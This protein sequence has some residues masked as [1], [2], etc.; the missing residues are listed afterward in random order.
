MNLKK[1]IYVSP[2]CFS[3]GLKQWTYEY[4]KDGQF[5]RTRPF[6]YHEGKD[7]IR[8]LDIDALLAD[9]KLRMLN[10]F[11]WRELRYT[12]LGGNHVTADGSSIT[13]NSRVQY[14]K[15]LKETQR[16]DYQTKTLHQLNSGEIVLQHIFEDEGRYLGFLK[17]IGTRGGVRTEHGYCVGFAD[18]EPYLTRRVGPLF[19]TTKEQLH[20]A[21]Q[22][23]KGL[24]NQKPLLSWERSSP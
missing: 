17:I 14:V 11:Q 16:T 24:L 5:F 10:Q 15:F 12:L 8:S 1:Y 7:V 18:G 19:E 9:K 6:G 23:D 2:Q 4:L 13:F 21:I 3:K 20:I 22:N